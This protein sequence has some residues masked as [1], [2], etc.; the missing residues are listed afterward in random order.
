MIWIKETTYIR[1]L[2]DSYELHFNLQGT[3]LS[4]YNTQAGQYYTSGPYDQYNS[5]GLTYYY[6]CFG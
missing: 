4:W 3:T 5:S 6:H 2:R 1:L